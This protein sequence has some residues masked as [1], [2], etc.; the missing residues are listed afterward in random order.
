LAET[1]VRPDMAVGLVRAFGRHYAQII[2]VG[3]TAFIKHVLELGQKTGVD[4]KDLLVHVAVGEETLAEN[5]RIYLEHIL[6]TR[7]STPA[8]GV[9]FSSMG[10]AELGLNLF[11]EAPPLG[12]L[13]AFRRALH[14]DPILRETV[15]GPS[16]WVPSLFTYDP[17]RIFVEFGPG[18]RLILTTLDLNLR[19]PLIRYATGDRGHFVSLRP[20]LREPLEKARVPWTELQTIPIVAISGRGE[21]VL[22]GNDPV[23]PEAV[24]EG[25]YHDPALAALTT[26]NFR[27][28][29]RADRAQVRVQLSPGI[30]PTTEMEQ[31]FQEAIT[32]YARTALKVVCQAYG[33]FGSGMTLDYERKFT[34]LEQ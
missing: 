13:V 14:L 10:V 32:P 19:L 12:A 18:G 9:I 6:G 17:G 11:A 33:D 8:D 16:G 5:A 28:A 21:H 1:S 7:P 24:K 20:E 15:L 30:E 4:W 27:L 26:A 3:E 22:S 25:I 29:A 2:L 31:A 23:Y 34:Y